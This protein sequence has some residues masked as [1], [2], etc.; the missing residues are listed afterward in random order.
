MTRERKFKPEPFILQVAESELDDL[1]RRLQS[2][3]WP[4][5]YANADWSY[6]TPADWLRDLVDYWLNHYD[7]RAAERAINAFAHY[8][9]MVDDVPIHFIHERGRGPDPIPIILTHGWPWTFWDF[10]QVIGA[11]TDPAAHGGDPADSFD[12]IVPSLPGFGFSG[13]LTRTGI[14]FWTTA[15]LWHK[16]MT[17]I[18]GYGRYAAHGGDW[19]ALVSGQLGHKYASALHGIHVAMVAPLHLFSR[20]RAWDIMGPLLAQDPPPDMRAGI[21][22]LDRRIASHVTVQ[23]LDPQSLAYGM[24]DSPVALAAWL[25]ERRH[26]WSV[27]GG[28]IESAFSRDFLIT[29]VMIYWLSQSFVTSARY[30]AEAER[31]PWR[32]SH[33]RVPLVEAPTGITLLPGDR[34][35]FPGGPPDGLYNLHYTASSPRGGHFSAAEVPQQIVADIR[36]TFRA[37]R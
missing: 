36:A 31:N 19:G 12:V 32:P 24:H 10:H 28:E 27:C 33:D 14:N 30:Y 18:L 6:G 7:W 20:E 29:T 17:E 4:H 26:A 8:R 37:L 3:R 13:P 35:S 15:D 34:A 25:L 5:D 16:L 11:L 21:V 23:M 1:R 2:T 22:A 9:V